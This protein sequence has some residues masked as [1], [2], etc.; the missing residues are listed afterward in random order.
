LTELPSPS[1]GADPGG[2]D[3]RS[4]DS[5]AGG[6]SARG[7][8]WARLRARAAE[9]AVERV[10]RQR[11]RLTLAMVFG[12]AALVAVLAIFAFWQ[13][14][15]Q[16]LP[17]VPDAASLWALNRQPAVE[18]V[19]QSGKTLA[20]RGPNYG[21]MTPLSGMPR[22]LIEAFLAI[23]DRRF[24]EHKGV[25][26]Q[27]IFRAMVVNLQAG[28]IVQGGS[29]ITQ[30]LAKN[31]FLTAD[32]T[33][34]RKLQEMILAGR[35]ENRL[36]KD[37]ILELYLNRVDLGE[38][39]FGID[40]AARRYFGKT[41]AELTLAESAMLAGLPKAPYENAPTRNLPGAKRRQELVLLA[42][43]EAGFVDAA[44]AQA[45]FA[46][47]LEIKGEGP[48]EGELGY[49]LDLAA[50]QARRQLGD[51]KGERFP[52]LI[53]QL[54]VDLALQDSAV[55]ILR[56]SLGPLGRREEDPLQGAI[57]LVDTNGAVRALV[58]GTSYRGSKFNRA[59]QALRQPGSS[60]KT[61]VYA[62]AFEQGLDPDAI[63]H[64]EPI[65]LRGWKPKNYD[66]G[67]RGAMTLRSAFADSINT[68]AAEVTYEIGPQRVADLARRFGI[69]TLPNN[70]NI[71][72]S[73]SLGSFEVTLL[74]MT[75]SFAVFMNEG[76]RTPAHW[77]TKIET[78][79]GEALYT[80][81]QTQLPQIFDKDLAHRMNEMMGRV[82]QR[83]T[84][85]RAQLPGRD[86]AGKTG[87][88][89]DWRDAWFVGYT[90]NYTAGV[91]VGFDS[92]REMPR[93]TGGG[94]PAE[95]WHD[96]MQVAHKDLPPAKLPGMTTPR[97]T[98]RS[99]EMNSFFES[100]AEAFGKPPRRDGTG[101]EL[102]PVDV[103]R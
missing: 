37:E 5:A 79:R 31:L 11:T 4:A 84:G 36:T 76:R 90:A 51:A 80:R 41:A 92:S 88:S 44:T 25:D 61:F 7:P 69:T 32:Q 39:S 62:A 14:A 17:R 77:I 13:W 56:Q 66:E 82:V 43:V 70:P 42:M 97:E 35:I 49:F 2:L 63:R 58:G 60:F 47:P 30:Q 103:S 93:I 50:E 34:R 57:V 59:A 98:R 74:D 26:R 55:Q 21:R 16:G 12:G 52:D 45:A 73:I 28:R 96:L 27:G 48:P 1:T 75:Q 87:T 9:Q 15:V 85:V 78:S 102:N 8:D 67:F 40:A 100:L 86:S 83:G 89:Q 71:T 94:T 24:Y 29:T 19:D 72:L 53:V 18:F 64:D 10:A 91:W 95:I 54:T 22:H 46:A 68:I 6:A 20:V 81:P 38:Q 33:A 101:G 65:S 99:Q 23:E 3:P